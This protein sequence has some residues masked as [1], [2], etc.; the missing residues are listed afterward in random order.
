MRLSS[1][2]L[3]ALHALSPP[4]AP[5]VTEDG[6]QLDEWEPLV[7]TSFASPT[8]DKPGPPPL[9]FGTLLAGVNVCVRPLTKVR[10]WGAGGQGLSRGHRR[11]CGSESDL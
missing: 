11:P 8:L 10:A 7:G 5:L 3:V 2:C 9:T 1:V 4:L 6:L